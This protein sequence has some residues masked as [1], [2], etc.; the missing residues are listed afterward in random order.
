ML[1]GAVNSFG[2]NA[3][4]RGMGM[5]GYVLAD[6]EAVLFYNPAGLGLKNG[7]WNGGAVSYFP[8]VAD[9]RQR[10]VLSI[11]YKNEKLDMLG[12][13]GQFYQL[14]PGFY[15]SSIGS[16]WRFFS[17][18]IIDNSIGI[19]LKLYDYSRGTVFYGDAGYLFQVIKRFRIGAVVKTI[20][21]DG[22]VQTPFLFTGIG[23]KD[24]FNG[25]T[26]HVIDIS[27]ELTYGHWLF[28]P[29]TNDAYFK[30]NLNYGFELTFLKS[31]SG[32]FGFETILSQMT[33]SPTIGTGISLFNHFD[34]DIF[35][36]MDANHWYW[37]SPSGISFSFKRILNWSRSDLNW[38]YK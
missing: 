37:D 38:W 9:E 35:A 14:Y 7:R 2:Q 27:T 28:Y 16:G 6:D 15:E 19:S 32:R 3:R 31:F 20:P 36:Y 5:A 4:T 33:L 10:H 26:Y 11:A 24:S 30:G 12:F 18:D 29:F 1:L 13:S 34:I 21:L 23:Y 25:N 8:D 22:N 17:N